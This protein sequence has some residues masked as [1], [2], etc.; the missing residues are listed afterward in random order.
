VY[1]D[2]DLRAWFRAKAEDYFRAHPGVDAAWYRDLDFTPQEAR[3]LWAVDE[4]IVY[5]DASGRFRLPGVNRSTGNPTEP[6]LFSRPETAMRTRVVKLEWREYLTQVVALAE[7]ISRYGWP[8]ELVAFDP[9]AKG[10]WTFDLAAFRDR[11][12]TPPWVIAAETKS[13]VSA[14]EL[15]DLAARLRSWS[16]TGTSPDPGDGSKAA[17]AFHGLLRT[18]PQWL[19]LVA[20]GRQRQAYRLVY[21]ESGRLRMAEAEDLPRFAEQG[22]TPMVMA[23]SVPRAEP[24]PRVMEQAE[25]RPTGAGQ[26]FNVGDRVRARYWRIGENGVGRWSTY[27]RPHQ[28]VSLDPPEGRVRTAAQAEPG[29]G[30]TVGRMKAV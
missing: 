21:H 12:G 19:W 6:R 18:R 22:A 2:H 17:K 30:R 10:A 23:R 5:V 3:F 24:E 26:A 28:I 13:P 7:L 15:G 4:G 16:D 11:S 8:K 9:E 29:G 14:R 20:P 25:R 27:R 1:D